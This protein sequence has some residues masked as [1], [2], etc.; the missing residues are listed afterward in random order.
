MQ[1]PDSERQLT[2]HIRDLMRNT[3]MRLMPDT[4]GNATTKAKAKETVSLKYS[5]LS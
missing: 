3:A 1:E 4:V 5:T 2:A